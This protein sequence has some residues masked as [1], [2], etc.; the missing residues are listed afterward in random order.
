M[1]AR[2]GSNPRGQQAAASAKQWW[3][4]LTMLPAEGARGRTLMARGVFIMAIFILLT[5]L[6]PAEEG[7][8]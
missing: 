2:A 3:A 6:A 8:A 7:V 5:G 1:S 4:S